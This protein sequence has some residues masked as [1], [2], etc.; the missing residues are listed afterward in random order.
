MFNNSYHISNTTG[1]THNTSH[2]ISNATSHNISKYCVI[3]AVQWLKSMAEHGVTNLFTHLFEHLP[4]GDMSSIH[5]S[6]RDQCSKTW[7][8]CIQTTRLADTTN[9]HLTTYPYNSSITSSSST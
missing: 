5:T 6:Y 3:A 4:P 2:I 7:H 9:V 8:S 1:C